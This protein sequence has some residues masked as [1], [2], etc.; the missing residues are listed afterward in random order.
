MSDHDSKLVGLI[1]TA[2][3]LLVVGL[4][5]VMNRPYTENAG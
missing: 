3:L 2:C 1:V 4:V 5:G